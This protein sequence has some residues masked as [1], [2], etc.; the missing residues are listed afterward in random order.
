MAQP[1]QQWLTLYLKNYLIQNYSQDVIIT[2]KNNFFL[3]YNQ[4]MGYWDIDMDENIINT[5]IQNFMENHTWRPLLDGSSFEIIEYTEQRQIKLKN[6]ITRDGWYENII[7]LFKRE[8]RNTDN[9]TMVKLD[10]LPAHSTKSVIQK[11]KDGK[12]TGPKQNLILINVKNGVLHIDTDNFEILKKPHDKKHYFTGRLEID[13]SPLEEAPTWNS[14]LD[15][16]VVD[17]VDKEVV[18]LYMAYSL[19]SHDFRWEAGLYIYGEGA[20]GKGTLAKSF[21]EMFSHPTFTSISSLEKN[22]GLMGLIGGNFW[23][24][25]ESDNKTIN[26]EDL[27]RIISGEP[28]EIDIKHNKPETH[29]F[30]M[31]VMITANEIPLL[32]KYADKRRFIV[33]RFPN[34]FEGQDKDV[35]L[36]KKLV[37]ELPGLLNMLV[38][39]IP[40][41]LENSATLSANISDRYEVQYEELADPFK[42]FVENYITQTNLTTDFVTTLDITMAFNAWA[43]KNNHETQNTTTTGRR[44]SSM[45][46]GIKKKTYYADKIVSMKY[47][48]DLEPETQVEKIR[49]RGYDGLTLDF[50]EIYKINPQWNIEAI[51]NHHLRDKNAGEIFET[52]SSPLSRFK[53]AHKI[54][55]MSEE[56]ITIEQVINLGKIQGFTENEVMQIVNLMI[57]EGKVIFTPNGEIK[58]AN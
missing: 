15:A 31:K 56:T 23:W 52:M 4:N 46:R 1:T 2:D 9:N 14:F 20:N 3:V 13:Y 18:K 41:Y 51:N 7:K 43:I 12:P 22:F 16:V 34:K 49:Q 29:Y 27:K 54:H 45:F 11:M 19:L 39:Q 42:I 50:D 38:D 28:V 33:V 36:D 57:S 44:V 48:D 47:N 37:S 58:I 17:N 10:S 26:T 6:I 55:A 30:K 40:V 8:L 35:D 5:I 32:K 21:K 53:F 24:A 25:N